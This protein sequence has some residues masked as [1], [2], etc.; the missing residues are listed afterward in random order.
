M[1][2]SIRRALVPS[3]MA[4]LSAACPGGEG[5][6]AGPPQ[7]T[8]VNSG[9]EP[10]THG[11]SFANYPSGEEVPVV[12]TSIARRL[13]GDE[14]C[15]SLVDDECV[16]S[17]AA[18]A[19]I[20]EVNG[21]TEGGHCEGFAVLSQLAWSGDVDLTPFGGSTAASIEKSEEIQKEI[22]YWYATQW[23]SHVHQATRLMTVN[24]I[25]VYLQEQFAQGKEGDNFRLGL[26]QVEGTEVTGGHAVTPFSI[27]SDG[28]AAA[29]GSSTKWK[30]GVYDSNFP[31]ETRYL[32]IDTATD[33][34]SYQADEGDDGRFEGGPGARNRIYVVPSSVRTGTQPCHFCTPGGTDERHIV[35]FKGPLAVD[36]YDQDRNRAGQSEDGLVSEI[37]GVRVIPIFTNLALDRPP[38]IFDAS[39][40]SCATVV[41]R[42]IPARPG[43]SE[44][45]SIT[46]TLNG[47]TTTVG[48]TAGEG[49]H[50]LD[51]SPEG[52]NTTYHTDTGNGG[53]LTTTVPTSDGSTV[54]TS[55]ESRGGAP[56][57][58]TVLGVE[59]DP[60]TGDVEIH[61]ESEDPQDLRVTMKVVE[62]DG[63]EREGVFTF[64]NMEAGTLATTT[65]EFTGYDAPFEYD[66]GDTGFVEEVIEAPACTSSSECPPFGG[67][68][69]N[70]SDAN[71]NCPGVYNPE[72]RDLDGDGVGDAC[73]TDKDGDGVGGN[74]DCNDYDENNADICN[75]PAGTFDDDGDD[76]T[77]C[78]A[79]SAGEYCAGAKNAPVTCPAGFEDADGDPG[80]AC[81]ACAAG[82]FC[83][84]GASAPVACPLGTSDADDDPATDCEACAP[85][86]YCEGGAV[87]ATFCPI[88][89]LDADSNAATPCVSCSAGE[90]CAAGSTAA[91]ACPA[92]TVDGD[93]TRAPRATSA[94]LAN[95]APAA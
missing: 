33:S 23:S 43:Q 88:G 38:Y 70:I 79:C 36:V 41:A 80:T 52:N 86:Q 42:T 85:G 61:F 40:N 3:L 54:T 32:H 62:A 71:D 39:E 51:L 34:W 27:E 48:G 2:S 25:A 87:A 76:A 90:Y 82:E 65:T 19:W 78:V 35:G 45:I 22:A 73:D 24:E 8:E 75:C 14:V 58:E 92:G 30:I 11:F 29:D 4:L 47:N 95:T 55:I 84:G 66:R 81:T 9:F 91:E 67:D 50:Y 20:R 68:A 18:E 64:E 56:G 12:D 15:Q 10:D 6:D 72:Q 57:S 7:L 83:A 63:S 59:I 16:L 69:D 44:E 46:S 1:T 28:A 13:F 74:L 94:A 53:P 49:T 17:P 21:T 26:L 60:D 5:L 89:T 37:N 93:S 31:G 77:A